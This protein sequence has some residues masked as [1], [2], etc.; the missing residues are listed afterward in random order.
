VNREANCLADELAKSGSSMAGSWIHWYWSFC[1][2]EFVFFLR[3]DGGR[4]CV[5][6]DSW[7]DLIDLIVLV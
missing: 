7:Q 6:F 5:C 1:F 2:E 4:C 3:L